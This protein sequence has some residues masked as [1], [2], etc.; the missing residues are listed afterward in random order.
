MIKNK[1]LSRIYAYFL[2]ILTY[3]FKFNV[4]VD[5]SEK[6]IIL[7]LADIVAGMDV[8][9]ALSYKDISRKNELTVRALGAQTLRMAVATVTGGT[10]S[11]LMREELKIHLEHLL[12][13]RS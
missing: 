4:A 2:A 1:L 5:K 13:L 12:Y 9:S 10:H 3:S 7:A 8:C 11:L 6:C